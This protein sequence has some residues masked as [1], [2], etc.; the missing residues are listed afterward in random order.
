MISTQFSKKV[1][2][3]LFAV[4][5]LSIAFTLTAYGQVQTKTTSAPEGAPTNS[6]KV[7]RGTVVFD[8]CP[9]RRPPAASRG[10]GFVD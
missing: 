3:G 5:A 1:M 10:D 2:H 9:T 8:S 6:F 7:D 4:G